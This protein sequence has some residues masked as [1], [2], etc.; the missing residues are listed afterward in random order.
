MP[1][2]GYGARPP[3]TK[4]PPRDEPS[5]QNSAPEQ[6]RPPA[7]PIIRRLSLRDAVHGD[8]MT[9][10][11]KLLRAAPDPAIADKS[12]M[13]TMFTRAYRYCEPM[14][15]ASGTGWYM[16]SPIDIDLIFD[17]VSISWRPAGGDIF[18]K[19]TNLKDTRFRDEF[20]MTCPDS[21]HGLAPVTIGSTIEPG[22]FQLWS[23]YLMEAPP[24]YSAIVRNPPNLPTTEN[25][26]GY[27]GIIRADTWLG[28][29]LTN[30]R[31]LRTDTVVSLR[32]NMPV[33]FVQL[34]RSEDLSRDIHAN[35]TIE[36]G[37]EAF[38]DPDWSKFSEVMLKSGNARGAYA[39]KTRRAQASS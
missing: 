13:G 5:A 38:R 21:L 12:A 17:G 39:R 11:L 9:R 1:P 29:L 31:I 37:I 36:T 16:F 19:L 3:L 23:G 28:P 34:I 32:R 8:P 26:I 27:E 15:L 18:E 2:R 10:F 7:T 24:G 22:V 14:R 33:F 25:M 20:E 6:A 4:I 30:I 35:M